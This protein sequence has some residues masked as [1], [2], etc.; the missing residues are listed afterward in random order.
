MH[1]FHDIVVLPLAYFLQLLHSD[2][3]QIGEFRPSLWKSQVKRTFN[4]IE[5]VITVK[6]DS[7]LI[8]CSPFIH[9]M[10]KMVLIEKR[11]TLGCEGEVEVGFEA[12]KLGV[13]ILKCWG[14]K[15]G[16]F[17]M[18]KSKNTALQLM[19]MYCLKRWFIIN[20]LQAFCLY[21]C[22]PTTHGLVFST[23]P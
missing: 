14:K 13:W 20:D 22:Y 5:T 21:V 23:Q 15:R 8:C 12:L 1:R 17:K 10:V 6:C 16:W 7:P 9:Q 19:Y 11:K 18:I 4:P 3:W 2:K